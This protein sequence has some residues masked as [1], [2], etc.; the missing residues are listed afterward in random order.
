MLKLWLAP[1]RLSS[2]TVHSHILIA[3][4]FSL[5]R[6]ER[7]ERLHKTC[8]VA[9]LTA[10][11]AECDLAVVLEYSIEAAHKTQPKLMYIC[12]VLHTLL[13]TWRCPE[14]EC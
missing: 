6:G 5:R 10:A 14:A 13:M 12:L 9:E 4:R 3:E 7:P 2:T 1:H 8:P 11:A